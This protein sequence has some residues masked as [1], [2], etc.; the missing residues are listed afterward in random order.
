VY[1]PDDGFQKRK[2]VAKYRQERYYVL[3]YYCGVTELIKRL[4]N[5]HKRMHPLKLQIAFHMTNYAC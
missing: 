1:L 3:Y 4:N 5:Q 2:H